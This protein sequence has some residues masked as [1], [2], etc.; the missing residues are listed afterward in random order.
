M[1]VVTVTQSPKAKA[2][3]KAPPAEEDEPPAATVSDHDD[4]N[5]SDGSI[6]SAPD[7][8]TCP[9]AF[10]DKVADQVAAAL[11]AG[12]ID[13][14][15][16]VKRVSEK[17]R[18]KFDSDKWVEELQIMIAEE[19]AALHEDVKD[20]SQLTD[21][22]RNQIDKALRKT[23]TEDPDGNIDPKEH[24]KFVA[25]TVGVQYKTK[26]KNRFVDLFLC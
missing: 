7:R 9:D 12:M 10:L 21:D 3:A 8:E 19:K 20:P 22:L 17:L 11:D 13:E 25:D 4:G 26:V 1:D 5:V 18:R 2:K 14:Q 23:L 16:I 24:R 6:E 15:F